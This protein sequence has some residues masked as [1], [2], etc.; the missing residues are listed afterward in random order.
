M[1]PRVEV[2]EVAA[3]VTS[4]QAIMIAPA[5]MF[6]CLSMPFARIVEQSNPTGTRRSLELVI[7]LYFCSVCASA[8]NVPKPRSARKTPAKTIN[9]PIKIRRLKQADCETD[10]FFM[11][12]Y[13]RNGL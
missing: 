7:T 3:P 10:F 8:E 2:A 13:E 1:G 5:R 6:S 4:P 9:T 11:S 12:G